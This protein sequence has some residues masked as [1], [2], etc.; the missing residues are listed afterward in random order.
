MQ[1]D[2]KR[3]INENVRID[4]NEYTDCTFVNCRVIFSGKGPTR[5]T[6]CKFDQCTW[7]FD[8]PA[9][10]T[11]QYLAALYSGL[12]P[13]G[14]DLIEAVFDSIRQGGVSTGELVSGSSA[15]LSRR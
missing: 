7:V 5:F 15:E 3:F 14:Q 6:N 11:I 2:H 13:G 4:E 1:Y 10:E 12:G 9:E 8:G